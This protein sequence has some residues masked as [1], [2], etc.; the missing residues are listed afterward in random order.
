MPQYEFVSREDGE[1]ITLMR[2]MRDADAAVEDPD[3]R[4]RT[5]ERVQSTFTVGASAPAR[6]APG[7]GGCPCGDPSGPCGR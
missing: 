4:G 2:P 1:R 6:S 3:G 7:L 5:F